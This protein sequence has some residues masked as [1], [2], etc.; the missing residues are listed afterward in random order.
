MSRNQSLNHCIHF[1]IYLGTRGPV[2]IDGNYTM[3]VGE[4]KELVACARV[5][6]NCCLR[7]WKVKVKKCFK[8]ESSFFVYYLKEAD[9]CPMAYCAG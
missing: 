3:P 8:N 9:G 1:H 4:T 2:W 5:K 7:S 6:E